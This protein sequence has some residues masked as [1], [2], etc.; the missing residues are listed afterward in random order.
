MSFTPVKQKRKIRDNNSRK[1]RNYFDYSIALNLI[2]L[3]IFT[4]IYFF[5]SCYRVIAPIKKNEIIWKYYI[6]SKMIHTK[7]VFFLAVC[8]VMD[9]SIISRGNRGM[10]PFMEAHWPSQ[11]S[12]KVRRRSD[13][14]PS[15]PGPLHIAPAPNSQ[16]LQLPVMIKTR[17]ICNGL[18]KFANLANLLR[19]QEA[20]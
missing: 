13:W 5:L 8:G 3:Y 20:I 4:Y 18:V 11:S 16:T 6:E 14:P 7:I 19:S 2:E 17:C 12:W 9:D 15:I 1:C 10:I